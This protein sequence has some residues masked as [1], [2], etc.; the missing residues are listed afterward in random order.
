MQCECGGEL[1]LGRTHRGKLMGHCQ[2]C[3]GWKPIDPEIYKAGQKLSIRE[4]SSCA[5]C[6]NTKLVEDNRRMRSALERIV[7]WIGE[8]PES[9]RFW[10]E[11]CTRP[12]SYGALHSG[13]TANAT[14]CVLSHG[15]H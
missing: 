2:T 8:F 6:C 13:A 3:H 11:E 10:D 7:R 15:K 12:M 4:T 14:I 5:C 1:K 9:G